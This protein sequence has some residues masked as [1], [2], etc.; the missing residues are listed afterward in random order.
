MAGVVDRDIT[1]IKDES[2]SVK[3]WQYITP[4]VQVTRKQKKSVLSDEILWKD[5][6]SCKK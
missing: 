4:L 3:D 5:G 6:T 1:E 2:C